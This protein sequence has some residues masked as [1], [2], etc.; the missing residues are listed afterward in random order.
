MAQ[1]PLGLVLPPRGIR[2]EI[3][4]LVRRRRTVRHRPTHG[5]ES[6]HVSV[7][8]DRRVALREGERVGPAVG[9][10]HR[11]AAK[12]IDLLPHGTLTD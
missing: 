1:A 9:G 4:D 12:L 10:D 5:G 3:G 7:V 2:L 11:L 8:T 6:G